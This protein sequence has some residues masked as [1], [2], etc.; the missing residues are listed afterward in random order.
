MA[1]MTLHRATPGD[2]DTLLGL[3]AQFYGHFGYTFEPT[4]HRKMLE[5]FI[6]HEYMGSLW[7]V[8]VDG[9][10][11]G[12]LALTYGYTFEFGGRDAF[13]DEFF[14]TEPY[15]NG[16]FG[17][18]ALQ[19]IQEKMTALGLHAIHLHTE[20]YN[21]RAKRLYESVGFVDMKRATLTFLPPKT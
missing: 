19:E 8:R 10:V 9:E 16:G 18:L 6:T 13:V 7:L 15:R 1:N 21:E 2:I 11:A 12:Y 20:H 3:V 4:A 14:M 5:E 17:R